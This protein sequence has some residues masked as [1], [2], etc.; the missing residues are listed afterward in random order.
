MPTN[1]RDTHRDQLDPL[2]GE[3]DTNIFF[4]FHFFPVVLAAVVNTAELNRRKHHRGGTAVVQFCEIWSVLG[5]I[6]KY[7]ANFLGQRRPAEGS[8]VLLCVFLRICIAPMRAG[9]ACDRV[10]IVCSRL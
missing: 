10:V 8:A 4:T 2:T 7:E 1:Y 9:A 6:D 5:A 3:T